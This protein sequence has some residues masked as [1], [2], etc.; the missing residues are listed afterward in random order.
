M[1]ILIRLTQHVSGIIMPIVGR[2]G[3]IKTWVW[4]MPCCV[5]CSRVELGHELCA[6]C[7]IK[8]WVWCMPCCVGC[9]RVELGHELC[10]LC[11][12][13]CTQLVSQLYTTAANPTR[14]TTHP[15]FFYYTVH[16][17]RVPS[18]HDCSQ[19]N[20]ADTTRSFLYSLFS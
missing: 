1:F 6:L 13:Q 10:A 9:S 19:H 15:V 17:A 18:L 3:Y 14:H 20:K 2:T 5:G 16:T 7:D 11:I 12:T 8:T 4:C